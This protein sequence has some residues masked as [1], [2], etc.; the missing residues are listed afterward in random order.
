MREGGG[1]VYDTRNRM[2]GV[3]KRKWSLLEAVVIF[4]I[5]MNLT[6]DYFYVFFFKTFF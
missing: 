4:E 3:S 1:G 2:V 5:M 6:T